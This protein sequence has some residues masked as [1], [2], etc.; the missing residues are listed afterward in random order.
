MKYVILKLSLPDFNA[1]SLW[2]LMIF[3]MA[4]KTK[5]TAKLLPIL[6]TLL[7]RSS[8]DF[9]FMYQKIHVQCRGS[10]RNVKQVCRMK[11]RNTETA[12]EFFCC[13]LCRVTSH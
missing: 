5:I 11:T 10:R 6:D 9:L 2:L 1:V 3:D 12:H 4:V 8:N 7:K 13:E